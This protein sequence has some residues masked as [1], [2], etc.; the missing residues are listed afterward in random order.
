MPEPGQATVRL[1]CAQ[2]W[3][4]MKSYSTAGYVCT[5][6]PRL[7]RRFTFTTTS[8]SRSSTEP[9]SSASRLYGTASAALGRFLMA[10]VY[11]RSWKVRPYWFVFTAKLRKDRLGPVVMDGSVVYGSC[12]SGEFGLSWLLMRELLR[13]VAKSGLPSISAG[14]WSRSPVEML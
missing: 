4:G 1:H 7:P 6:L 11:E 5:M 10:K 13:A 8:Q 14:H 2:I 9:G 3:S 12:S